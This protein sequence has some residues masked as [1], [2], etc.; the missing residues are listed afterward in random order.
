MAQ[1]N[2]GRWGKDDE[3]GTLNMQSDVTVLAALRLAKLGKVYPL[4][5]DISHNTRVPHTRNGPWR[6]LFGG[7]DPLH[8]EQRGS[9]DE[10]LVM[11]Y[12]GSSTHIDGLGHMWYGD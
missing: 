8:P 7:A 5:M 2:W 6:W 10:V 12:H 1:D 11:Q 4:A 3:R 9:A